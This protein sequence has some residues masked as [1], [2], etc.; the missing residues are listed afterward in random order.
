MHNVVWGF[1]EILAYF[2]CSKLNWN[3]CDSVH[4]MLFMPSL[5]D[6]M[7]SCSIKILCLIGMFILK[8]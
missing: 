8:I 3:M 4:K 7:R 1:A 6:A 5:A 2:I